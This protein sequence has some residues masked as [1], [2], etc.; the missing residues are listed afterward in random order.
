MPISSRESKVQR[1]P[2]AFYCSKILG[3]QFLKHLIKEGSPAGESGFIANGDN[4]R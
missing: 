3:A 1:V 4:D 2:L